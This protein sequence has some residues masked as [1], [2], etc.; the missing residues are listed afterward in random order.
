MVVT[1]VAFAHAMACL[2]YIVAFARHDIFMSWVW[3][4]EREQ[5]A[6]FY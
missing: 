1:R 3:F 2:M 6:S 4:S 5:V